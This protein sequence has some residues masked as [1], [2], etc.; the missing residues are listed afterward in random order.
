MWQKVL[1]TNKEQGDKSFIQEVLE[2]RVEFLPKPYKRLLRRR[3]DGSSTA[4][5]RSIRDRQRVE[6]SR[7]HCRS[8]N[9]AFYERSDEF[10]NILDT[11]FLFVHYY[12]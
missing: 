6:L 2:F 1:L 5:Y 7:R 8:Q 11:E 3:G 4:S 12:K 9:P 10:I